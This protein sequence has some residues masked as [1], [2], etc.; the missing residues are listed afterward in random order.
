MKFF[1]IESGESAGT[2]LQI[3]Q[4]SD[5]ER[6]GPNRVKVHLSS[7]NTYWLEE[8]DTRRLLLLLETRISK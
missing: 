4:I 3:D 2:F 5:V 6:F 7:G 8:D 1:K